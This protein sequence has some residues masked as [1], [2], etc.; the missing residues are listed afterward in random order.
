MHLV[1]QSKQQDLRIGDGQG[2]EAGQLRPA[3]LCQSCTHVT[4][5]VLALS[6]G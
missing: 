5:L 3:I 4:R 1:V 6:K 2:A